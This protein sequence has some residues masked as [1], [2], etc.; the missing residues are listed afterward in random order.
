MHHAETRA[1]PNCFEDDV[2]LQRLLR[3]TA[4]PLSE[5]CSPRLATFGA[6]VA[7]EVD[8]AAT[9]TDRFA[10]PILEVG[11]RDGELHHRLLCNPR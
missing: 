1:G 9:Y 5:R 11:D 4:A 3:R 2:N 8:R 6:W 7:S 10:P